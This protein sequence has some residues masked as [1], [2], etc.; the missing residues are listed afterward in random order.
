MGSW[1]TPL[2]SPKRFRITSCPGAGGGDKAFALLCLKKSLRMTRA[3]KYGEF[4]K[5]VENPEKCCR[6]RYCGNKT[7]VCFKK[8][9]DF[10]QMV[11]ISDTIT[12]SVQKNLV[13]AVFLQ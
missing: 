5:L 11:S 7:R 2:D 10:S 13:Y 8:S 4:E 3:T 6:W 1:P 12:Y 9:L